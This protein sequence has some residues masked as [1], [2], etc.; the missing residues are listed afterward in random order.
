MVDFLKCLTS[1]CF[2]F[3][4]RPSKGPLTLATS[5]VWPTRFHPLTLQDC[6]TCGCSVVQSSGNNT[7]KSDGQIQAFPA[8]SKDTV[9]KS[10]K[11]LTIIRVDAYCFIHKS[12]KRPRQCLLDKAGRCPSSVEMIDS[13]GNKPLLMSNIL[14]TRPSSEIHPCC[15]AFPGAN[16]EVTSHLGK[17]PKPLAC[18]MFHARQ[19][20]RPGVRSGP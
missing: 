6:L 8:H 3:Y 9:C 14:F 13:L 12:P 10:L 4:I 11:H 5:A 7:D 17:P 1:F 16:A 20:L 15:V 18:S 2:S 19:C